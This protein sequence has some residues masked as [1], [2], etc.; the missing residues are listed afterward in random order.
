MINLRSTNSRIDSEE[1]IMQ[2]VILNIPTCT[3]TWGNIE[4]YLHT[5]NQHDDESAE[6]Y[7]LVLLKNLPGD[8]RSNISIVDG[9]RS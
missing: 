2:K 9:R 8:R 1:L 5:I 3:L 7:I 6:S 4:C